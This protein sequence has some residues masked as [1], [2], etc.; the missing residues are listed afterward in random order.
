ME[1]SLKIVNIK[2]ETDW[3]EIGLRKRQQ[4]A[5]FENYIIYDSKQKEALELIKAHKENN[6]IFF[7]N[8]GT[9][10]GHL[11]I[12]LLKERV[13]SGKN[14]K[15]INALDLFIL[16]KDW[17]NLFEIKERFSTYDF[18]IIDEIGKTFKSEFDQNLLFNI[19][20]NRYEDYLQTILIT[21]LTYDDF[22]ALVT[23]PVLDRLLETYMFIHFCWQSYRIQKNKL[24]VKK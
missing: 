9:G 6:F 7:G 17:D 10:K 23:I 8:S 14:C 4:E 1:K 21:N 11:A 22:S 2:K 16:L 18:L 13:R 15:Y 19:L 12:S 20:N 3:A 5:E 24:E